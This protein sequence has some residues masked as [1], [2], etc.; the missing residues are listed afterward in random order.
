MSAMTDA[1]VTGA[2][3]SEA[4][5]VTFFIPCLNEERHVCD[6]L[7]KLTEVAKRLGL[8][9]EILVVDDASTD[10]TVE[11]VQAWRRAHPDEPVRLL[12]NRVN[13]GLARNFVEGAFRGRG[14]YY[15]MVCG[16][17]TEPLD[18]HFEIL[19]RIGEADMIL[20]D[21]SGATGRVGG[22][23]LVSRGY[24]AVVNLISGNDINYYNGCALLRREDVLRW[25][26]EATGFGF[27]AELLTR[28]FVEGRSYVELTLPAIHHGESRAVTFRNVVSVLYS[29]AKIAARRL[30]H[31]LNPGR[32]QSKAA[33]YEMPPP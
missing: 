20:P 30:S 27:Q 22:R 3:T 9:H 2:G 28:L 21:Y 23:A 32:T 14:E 19:K 29:L 33:L 31:W 10:R 25:H 6:V 1:T 11:K 7:E 13:Q 17:D 15:R 18:T 26:V 24:T 12:V 16:D 4:V 5:R 8:G